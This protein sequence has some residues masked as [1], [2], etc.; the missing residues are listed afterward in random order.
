MGPNCSFITRGI[1][2]INVVEKD[3]PEAKYC[4]TLCVNNLGV[5]SI[6]KEFWKKYIK[7]E[8]DAAFVLLHELMHVGLGDTTKKINKAEAEI[9][10]IAMDIRIN[11]LVI[12]LLYKYNYEL[13]NLFTV[14]FYSKHN[15]YK[16]LQHT[17]LKR[18]NKFYSLHSILYTSYHYRNA[19]KQS[20][21]EESIKNT[22]KQL[23]SASSVKNVPLL[24][25]HDIPKE[26]TKKY[27]EAVRNQLGKEVQEII[28]KLAKNGQLNGIF[29]DYLLSI[30]ESNKTLKLDVLKKFAQNK[31]LNQLASF[32][33]Q[34]EIIP[35]VI[36][37]RPSKA[38]LA[39]VSVGRIP[40]FWHNKENIQKEDYKGCGI[41][42][43][44]SGSLIDE[45]PRILGLIKKVKGNIE[46]IYTFS[47][48]VY[49]QTTKELLTGKVDTTGGTD[50]DC[51][52]NHAVEK[53]HKK[54]IV[55]TDGY[56]D[57]SNEKAK[58]CK[59]K[60]KDIAVILTED[61]NK[62]NPFSK[63]YNKTYYLDQLTK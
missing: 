33:Y 58:I 51:I 7:T 46:L 27:K 1:R 6:N 14:K 48:K 42:L 49:E 23:M 38:D 20:V 34:E 44:V 40:I 22:I 55:I 25:S 31:D 57:L 63:I 37:I 17:A 9:A 52:V 29:S 2:K 28:S 32:F 10:N 16:I 35:N 11:A 62:N 13:D 8:L 60:I 56:A 39:Q 41:Y 47:N 24:G 12:S 26:I 3:S 59:T 53:K 19:L 4:K 30:I 18:N 50:F 36:P 21:S 43:D 45:V 5:I 15:D 54:F 61:S